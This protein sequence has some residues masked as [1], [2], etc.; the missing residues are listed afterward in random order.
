MKFKGQRYP[1]LIGGTHVPE[2]NAI[3]VSRSC[4]PCLLNH[5]CFKRRPVAGAEHYLRWVSGL[6]KAC[7]CLP[8]AR[9]RL[10]GPQCAPG[11]S[12]A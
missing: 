6:L 10:H 7:A 8:L 11:T 5:V 2:L 4:G 3:E 12:A 9:F 1:V